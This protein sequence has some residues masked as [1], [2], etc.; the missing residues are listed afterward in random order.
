MR[1]SLRELNAERASEI[2]AK[3]KEANGKQSL[4]DRK[5]L[6]AEAKAAGLS[7]KDLRAKL[8]TEIKATRAEVEQTK[9]DIDK[10]RRPDQGADAYLEHPAT[11]R[12][13]PR[14]SRKRAE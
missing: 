2:A 7:V 14:K 10:T 5:A 1:K 3:T 13:G 4:L 6:S 12:R 8:S 9:A 11:L